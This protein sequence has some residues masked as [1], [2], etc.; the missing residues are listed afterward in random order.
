MISA[1]DDKRTDGK[2]TNPKYIKS[3]P[4]QPFVHHV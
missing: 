2:I 3:I 1:Q 4:Q